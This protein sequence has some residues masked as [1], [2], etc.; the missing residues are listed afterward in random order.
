M[1]KLSKVLL[2]SGITMLLTCMFF[3]PAGSMES[4]NPNVDVYTFFWLMAEITTLIGLSMAFIYQKA[5]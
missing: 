4:T 5:N 1:K 2:A 3:I